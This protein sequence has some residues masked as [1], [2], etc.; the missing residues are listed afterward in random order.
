MDHMHL[1]KKTL[2]L[3]PSSTG[4]EVRALHQL[5]MCSTTELPPQQENILSTV[6]KDLTNWELFLHNRVYSLF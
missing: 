4:I 2:F 6:L 3:D 1:I 5:G